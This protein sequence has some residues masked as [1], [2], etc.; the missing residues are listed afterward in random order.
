MSIRDCNTTYRIDDLYQITFDL[1]LSKIAENSGDIA[2][3]YNN[4][5]LFGF[6]DSEISSPIDD[7]KDSESEDRQDFYEL[8]SIM[9]WSFYGQW[10]K[11]LLSNSNLEKA[12]DD[13]DIHEVKRLFIDNLQCEEGVSLLAKLQK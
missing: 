8:I 11:N 7:L 5:T 4:K 9:A 2:P 3:P 12:F 6:Y 10:I 13:I 1:F